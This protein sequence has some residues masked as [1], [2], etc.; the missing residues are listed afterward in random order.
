M[1][2]IE[3]NGRR[4][5]FTRPRMPAGASSLLLLHGAGGSHLDWP[6]EVRR[7]PGVDVISLDLPGHGRSEGPGHDDIAAYGGDVA[8]FISA[9]GL[10]RVCVAGHSMGG[11]IA[12]W[13][14]VQRPQWL[15]SIVLIGSGPRLPVSPKILAALP[16]DPQSAVSLIMRYAWRK[17]SPPRLVELAAKA[18]LAGEPDQCYRDFLACDRFDLSGGLGEIEAPALA[19]F[20]EDDRLTPPEYGRQLVAG[21]PRARLLIIKDAGHYVMLEQPRAVAVAVS[22]FIREASAGAQDG[23]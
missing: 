16:V 17:E 14:A 3:A 6:R 8:A 23:S 22:A 4:F 20:G 15:A 21:I 2:I 1:P 12:Q 5:Y 18:M 13:L 11:A 19:I 10:E 7:L 9:L